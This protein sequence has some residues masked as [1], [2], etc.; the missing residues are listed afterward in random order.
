LN[1]DGDK[2]S[3]NDPL[4]KS[5]DVE[6]VARLAHLSFSDSEKEDMAVKLGSILDYMQ[7]LRQI[8]TLGVEATTHVLPL[9]NVFR[10]DQVGATL[11]IEAALANAPE[12][13]GNY[14]KVPK[15]L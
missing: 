15:I 7:Q 1:A 3:G 11:E 12:R 4:I 6:Y 10:A 8:D 14:F 13:E 5:T 9:A 2:M